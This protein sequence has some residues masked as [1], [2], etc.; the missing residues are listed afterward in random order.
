M[1]YSAAYLIPVALLVLTAC[2]IAEP[3][4]AK[5]ALP[6][7]KKARHEVLTNAAWAALAKKDYKTAN[8][9][10]DDC[11]D[12]FLPKALGMQKK[13]EIEK[14]E[15]AAGDVTEAE[16]KRI[17]ENGLL[18]DVAA[19]LYI[20]GRSAEHLKRWDDAEKA[21]SQASR[22]KHAR[23]LDKRG[24]FWSV[25]E[26]CEERAQALRLPPRQR[27]EALRELDKPPHERETGKAWNAFNKRAYPKAVA[28]A[29]KCIKQFS[30]PAQRL[31]NNLAKNRARVPVGIVT[32]SQK[33]KIFANGILNDVATCLFIKGRCAERRRQIPQ[34]KA[35]YSAARKLTYARC[36]DPNG[37]FFWSVSEAA[38]DRLALLQ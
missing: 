26:I 2:A 36:W 6:P 27:A 11:L 15:I 30:R 35:A 12:D 5:D 37:S 14:V 1:K 10:A 24:W 3:P 9:R 18:N 34:A 29:G 32:E 16:E 8:A 21:Y 13:L 22:Y 23:V 33:Q 7:K 28:H 17:F 31:Q 4:A 38:S 19:C 25:G 20:K